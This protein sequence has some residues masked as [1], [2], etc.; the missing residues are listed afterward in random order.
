MKA[1]LIL[2]V[3]DGDGGTSTRNMG[4]GVHSEI[5]FEYGEYVFYILAKLEMLRGFWKCGFVVHERES[6]A[7][8]I[9]NMSAD[10]TIHVLVESV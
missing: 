10:N 5:S 2:S 7:R 3:N 1:I 8:H 9:L 4:R 6:S